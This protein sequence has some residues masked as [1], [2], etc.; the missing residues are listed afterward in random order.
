MTGDD[1]AN[2]AVFEV[3]IKMRSKDDFE[4]EKN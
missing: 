1:Q 2:N 4:G 3:V